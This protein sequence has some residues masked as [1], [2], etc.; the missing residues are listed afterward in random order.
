[1][2]RKPAKELT[3]EEVL[4]QQREQQL[5]FMEDKINNLNEPTYKLEIKLLMVHL[6]NVPLQIYYMTERC[7]V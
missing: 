3:A 7:M 5:R 1:M 6:K 2:A 4:K